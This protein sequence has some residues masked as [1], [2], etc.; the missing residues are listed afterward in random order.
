MDGDALPRDAAR[1]AVLDLDRG[2]A[3]GV[4]PDPGVA[5]GAVSRRVL[6]HRGV[7]GDGVAAHHVVGA[8]LRR[9]PLDEGRPVARREVGCGAV[10]DRRIADRSPVRGHRDLVHECRAVARGVDV[11]DQ[12]AHVRDRAERGEIEGDGDG[13]PGRDARGVQRERL[14]VEHRVGPRGGEAARIGRARLGVAEVERGQAGRRAGHRP[15]HVVAADVDGV[16]SGRHGPGADGGVPVERVGGEQARPPRRRER[17]RID[18]A[19]RVLEH[20]VAPEQRG[21]GGVGARRDVRAGQHREPVGEGEAGGLRREVARV[22]QQVAVRG[23]R[24]GPAC[25]V[26]GPGRH[27]GRVPGAA[28]HDERAI[29]A[30]THEVHGVQAAAHLEQRAD[31]I[32][33]VA[34]RVEHRHVEAIQP[35]GGGKGGGVCDAGIHDHQLPGRSRREGHRRHGSELQRLGIAKLRRARRLSDD[36]E[37]RGK[38]IRREQGARL[39]RLEAEAAGAERAAR[40]MPGH[41]LC[42]YS[43][44]GL[45]DLHQRAGLRAH[46]LARRARRGTSASRS[47]TNRTCVRRAGHRPERCPFAGAGLR[48]DPRRQPHAPV[49]GASPST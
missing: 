38:Q 46:E 30:V 2:D 28:A 47:V 29:A 6:F 8:V 27:P 45:Q 33:R 48:S 42:A 32:D 14:L 25:H 5:V 49:G 24:L 11:E 16:R 22:E 3:R 13:F 40:T 31:L 41:V 43:G 7:A 10:H 44:A 23:K 15:D 20:P 19:V 12:E 17:A 26:G 4:E 9:R 37:V 34:R 36:E 21:A 39:Q 35:P 1:V 18:G